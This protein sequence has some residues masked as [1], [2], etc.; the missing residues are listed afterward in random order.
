MPAMGPSA[1]AEHQPSLLEARVTTAPAVPAIRKAV[2]GDALVAPPITRRLTVEPQDF[3]APSFGGP[4]I[5][6]VTG[7]QVKHETVLVRWSSGGLALA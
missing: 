5:Y 1:A 7:A 3:A 6:P 4:D 2:A